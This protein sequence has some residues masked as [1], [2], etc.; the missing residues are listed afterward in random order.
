VKFRCERDILA[1]ALATA[2]RAAAT[3]TGAFP[4]LSGVRLQLEADS[5]VVTGTDL[6]LTIDLKITVAGDRDGAVVLPARLVADIVKNLPS[7]SVELNLADDEVRINAGRSKFSVRPLSIDDFPQQRIEATETVTL[8]SDDMADAL[9][10]VVRAASSD[11]SRIQLTGVLIAAEE[12]GL[13]MVATDSYRLAV[14][15]LPQS[16]ILEAGQRVLVPSRALNE[17]QRLVSVSGELK[18]HLSAN[19]A[20]FEVGSVRLS[21]RLIENEYPNYANLVPSNNTNLL[22]VGREDLLSAIRRVKI[23]ASDNTPV[24]LDCEADQVTVSVVTQDVGTGSEVLE[25]RYEG[26]PM[27]IAFN[28]EFFMSGIDAIETDEVTL[29]T[30]ESTSPAVLRGA[31]RDDYLYLLMPVRLP[32]T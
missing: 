2:G 5:L 24:R 4:A 19:E 31:G 3:R 21:T 16:S 25:C 32:A 9:G 29:S 26:E 14:R 7:G 11:E 12:N 18:A 20:V 17:L 28:P 30:R 15:D 8:S 13:K 6:E 10:Q 22:T 23:L 27:S 1:E